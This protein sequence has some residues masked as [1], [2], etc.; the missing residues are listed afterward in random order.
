MKNCLLGLV[1]L[2]CTTTYSQLETIS[3][4]IA[5]ISDSTLVVSDSVHTTQGSLQVKIQ[6]NDASDL[7]ALTI[8]VSQGASENPDFVFYG[9]R[10]EIISQGLLTDQTVL[11][12]FPNL[13]KDKTYVVFIEAQNTEMNYLNSLTLNYLPN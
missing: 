7:G 2:I 4:E 9:S 8:R 5:F 1:L 10:A 6:L 12:Q 13:N 11:I 3:G